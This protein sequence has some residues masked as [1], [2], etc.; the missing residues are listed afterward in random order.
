M[1]K[2]SSGRHSADQ[3]KRVALYARVSTLDKG[4]DR[5]ANRPETQLRPLREY[6]SRRGFQIQGEYVDTASGTTEE[7]SQYH[8]MLELARKRKLDVVLVW[9]YDGTGRPAF[10]PVHSGIGQRPEGVPEPGC[11]LYLLSREH[12]HHHPNR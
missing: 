11:G 3:S 7:R 2:K 10:C 9:R 1:A 12:R 4:Q 6:A 8:A 5:A